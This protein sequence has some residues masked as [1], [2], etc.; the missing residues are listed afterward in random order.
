[1][2]D[3]WKLRLLK[4]A[5]VA[6]ILVI[7]FL[8][9]LGTVGI[10]QFTSKPVADPIEHTTEDLKETYMTNVLDSI[11]IEEERVNDCEE[12]MNRFISYCNDK[13]YDSAY[14]I[15]SDN[16]KARYSDSKERLN[17]FIDLYF[18]NQRDYSYQNFANYK[19]NGKYYIF[20]VSIYDDLM[21]YGNNQ[22]NNTDQYSTEFIIYDNGNDLTLTFDG[23]IYSENN[24]ISMENEYIRFNIITKDIYYDETSF[25][26]KVENLTKDK[27]LVFYDKDVRYFLYNGSTSKYIEAKKNSIVSSNYP[28]IVYSNNSKELT[29]TYDKYVGSS[30]MKDFRI[31]ISTIY[32]FSN[33]AILEVSSNVE[34]LIDFAEETYSNVYIILKN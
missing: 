25:T 20:K 13:D 19:N 2:N 22:Y 5:V 15:I 29:F 3:V 28:N 34:N 32:S 18:K 31:N 23:Y 26:I 17:K 9:S 12:L 16:Y 14:S 4:L 10:I 21:L 33:K 7:I 27:I 11:T 24:N 8:I 30:F 6:I 1:M